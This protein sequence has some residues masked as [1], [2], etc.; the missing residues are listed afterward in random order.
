VLSV[1][2]LFYGKKKG[3]Y[4]KVKGI[5]LVGDPRA[6]FHKMQSSLNVFTTD[7]TETTV[8]VFITI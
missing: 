8:R 2:G 7:T 1:A 4:L 6:S 5:D 3:L